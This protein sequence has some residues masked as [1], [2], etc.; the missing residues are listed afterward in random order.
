MDGAP[1]K[2]R[3]H[4]SFAA[5]KK[6]VGEIHHTSVLVGSIIEKGFSSPASAPRN[7]SLPKPSVLPFPAARHRSHGPHWVS[8]RTE[9]DVDEK[10][11]E[12]EEDVDNT[13]Y[14][15]VASMA[16]RI[17][18][19]EKKG[20]DFS[21]WREMV[22]EESS[23][24]SVVKK[25]STKLSERRGQIENK[26][27]RPDASSLPVI[28]AVEASSVREQ[29]GDA[30]KKDLPSDMEVDALPEV[31]SVEREASEA[32][33]I[34][35]LTPFLMDGIDAENI[36]RLKEMSPDEIGEARAEIMEKM[37]P[38]LVDMLRKRGKAKLE[39]KKDSGTV[40]ENEQLEVGCYP[41]DEG[42]K[43]SAM[44]GL[45]G[46]DGGASSTLWKDWSERVERVR[47]LRFSLEGNA[48]EIG[49]S[50]KQSNS[51]NRLRQYNVAERDFL[52]SEG[53]P[54]S[55]GYTIKEA[56]E[57]IRSM[58]PGQR[59]LA[60]QLLGAVLNQALHSLQRED[61]G[62]N[63]GKTNH[64]NRF[65]DWQ[66]VW[67]FALGPEPQIVLSLRI[68]LDDNHDSV[69]L[70]CAKVLQCILS[71][72]VNEKFFDI[73]EKSPTHLEDICIAPVFR[74]RP[75]ISDGFLRGGFWK[76]NAKP[77]NILPFPGNDDDEDGG[78]EKRTIQDDI[79]VAEQDVA[80]GLIRM[81]IL[82]RIC[83][84]LEMEP[85]PTL[86]E[87][88]VSI[89]VALAR[90]SPTSVNAILKCPRLVQ[91]VIKVF[92]KKGAMELYPSQIKATTFLKVLAKCSKDICTD[93]VK[94]GA[95]Q[96]AM[97][98]WYKNSF[99]LG[100]WIKSGKEYCR[101][102]SALMVEQLR[103]W[104]VCITYGYCISYF[105]DFFPAM[106]LWLSLPGFDEL[107]ENNILDEYASV[108]REA[109]LVLGALAQTL[110]NLHSMEQLNKQHI[111]LSGDNMEI[112]CWSYVTPMVDLAVNW[113][114]LKAI[115]VVSVLIGPDKK[116]INDVE[117]RYASCIL[118]VI[119]SVLHMLCIVLTRI[120]TEEMDDLQNN[121]SLPW[122]PKF[123]PKI[124]LVIVNNCLMNFL[125]S[126]DLDSEGFHSEGGSLTDVLCYFR[127]HAD[128]DVSLSSVSCLLGLVRI[129]SS[130]DRCIQR[131]R[132]AYC[133]EHHEGYSLKVAEK[134]L[135][136]GVVKWA[137]NDL[138]VVLEL[139]MTFLSSEWHIVQST[140][141]FGRGGPAP[142]IAVGWGS[143]GG[144][145]WSPRVS[146]A[147]EDSKLI[148][149]LIKIFWAELKENLVVVR[150]L[151]KENSGNMSLFL[152]EICSI[153]RVCL[154]V[155]P[156]DGATFAKALNFLLQAPILKY[157]T[158][159]VNNLCHV[160]GI[161]SFNLQ[162]KEEEYIFFSEVLNSH[163]QN[164]W[165]D[166]KKKSPHKLDSRNRN[167][168]ISGA[169]GA[170]GTIHEDLETAE[171]S[172]RYHDVNSLLIQWA[173]QRLPL[174]SH[175]FLSA[176]S[177]V[178]VDK[179]N[180]MY[181]STN[182][183]DVS[184]GGLLLLL[185]LE[186][187]FFLHF[188]QEESPVS[189]MP[190]VWKFH[191]LSMVLQGGM[192]VLLDERSRNIYEA[193]QELYG[194]QLDRLRS[195]PVKGLQMKEKTS[196]S[197]ATLVKD[198]VGSLEFLSFQT[199]IHES[200]TTF[201]ENLIEQFG[202]ISYGDLIYGRQVALYLHRS[203]EVAVRLAAWN[204]LSNAHLLELLPPLTQC[205]ADA[206][207]YLEPLEDN[208]KML[209]AYVRSWISG[210]LDRAA[211]RGSISFSLALHYLSCFIFNTV[212][213]SDKLSLRNKLAKSLLRS[214]SQK[215][216]Q[217]GMFLSFL[218][219]RLVE[220]E[221]SP[222]KVELGRRFEL[223]KEACEENSVLLAQVEKL[224]THVLAS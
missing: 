141:M 68:A 97:W 125:S 67:A 177:S 79:V 23:A 52:R 197:S 88:L 150:E 204:A 105:P 50:L 28:S 120:A 2:K 205:F 61:I 137:Q 165:L 86:E 138:K 51:Q 44:V 144:G 24:E 224:K 168:D 193:L 82:P 215:Q 174:P 30:R 9:M 173:H 73:L 119:S 166:V 203:V 146:L 216:H 185:G 140:E 20:L 160:M 191:A 17:Q 57:L 71:C 142:G 114:S 32:G 85:L 117:D 45:P 111:T 13:D 201:V 167:H 182:E 95:F 208:E 123:V 100:H 202:A 69:V 34:G 15:P 58:V 16:T 161:K 153:L 48:L 26:G 99:T 128:H 6:K 80:A 122:L 60:L 184:K 179:G 113:L 155:G 199:Q 43:S 65:V 124:G 147:Q 47:E 190:L 90:H 40:L 196:V 115:P 22:A 159:C 135:E 42:Q 29:M 189:G 134:I 129:S 156:G 126:G 104:K 149:D 4:A 74:S 66:A 121:T 192:D 154:I 39:K 27:S 178:G 25:K 31:R 200:Y 145:Y 139:F 186:A 12:E 18:R 8:A 89:L 37:D 41:V 92:N 222:N 14:E 143:S 218:K 214:F 94:S 76:Y 33:H 103:L 55:V 172:E 133:S 87:C 118:W 70:A 213:P 21:R 157:L 11:D 223:L 198:Q 56:V 35:G 176:I 63:D 211:T 96:K 217:E 98:L 151:E 62:F 170:L 112:W 221:E 209:E 106:C 54:A 219:Y 152:Q 72:D 75:E 107:I 220:S 188:V 194:K 19:K 93:I 1:A 59:A 81:G 3:S 212:S 127:C 210:G 5:A 77:S 101:L 206:V 131:A 175:W 38:R 84:L 36:A 162:Y 83:Y 132:K 64:M 110:P 78:E 10:D 102:A 53:D 195:I 148:L 91:S 181:S 136:E 183:L 108:T 49:S 164:R 116:L 158:F 109:Y 187:L 163:F 171:G 46:Q 169:I 207:G 7:V 180:S 130:V